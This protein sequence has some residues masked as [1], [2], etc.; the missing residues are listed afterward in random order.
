MK[1][2]GILNSNISNV[3]SKM[4]HTD[5]LCIGDS[6][7]PV[8]NGVLEIDVSLK[9]NIPDFI[10]VLKTIIEDM[11]IEKAYIAK[12]I[13][14]KN[15]TVYREIKKLIDEKKL[16]LVKHEELKEMS[17]NSKAI[18]R[19]GEVTPYANIILQSNVNF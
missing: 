8:P 16:V 11:H 7:L 3:L 12:E 13:I 18:I 10:T 4:R 15:E 1:K 19:T 9:A 6:G 5:Q 14:E 2:Q 17:Q